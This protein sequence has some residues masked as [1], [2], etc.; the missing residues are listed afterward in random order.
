MLSH[1]AAPASPK[2]LP[3]RRR[4]LPTHV[5]RSERLL[6][7]A[8]GD[9]PGHHSSSDE[10][11]AGSGASWSIEG[12]DFQ[13][14]E[15]PPSA[16][17]SVPG[18]SHGLSDS[19]RPIFVNHYHYHVPPP[20]DFGRTLAQTPVDA[21]PIEDLPPTTLHTLLPMLTSLQESGGVSN[22]VL[23]PS[24]PLDHPIMSHF[25]PQP[26][27]LPT[28]L[29]PTHNPI[30][31]GRTND[32]RRVSVNGS[33]STEYTYRQDAW[34]ASQ[35]I[36]VKSSA[37]PVTNPDR[38]PKYP[39]IFSRPHPPRP[40]K[41]PGSTRAEPRKKRAK[42]GSAPRFK[43][44]GST[45]HSEG[46]RFPNGLPNNGWLGPFCSPVDEVSGWEQ[47]WDRHSEKC[48]GD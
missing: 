37:C 29:N 11:S 34:V 22:P 48:Y 43:L 32:E 18:K 45:I 20:F 21:H 26:V 6:E 46:K 24:L 30:N 28:P 47:A 36:P 38:P 2:P 1:V 33:L 39:P 15:S 19:N 16:T 27:S 3:C 25:P 40:Q 9:P 23:T 35:G 10:S 44:P 17:L 14:P 12:A 5:P 41:R 42:S 4:F 31:G 7:S 8:W 13:Q